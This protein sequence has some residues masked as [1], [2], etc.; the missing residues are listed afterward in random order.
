MGLC[1][2]IQGRVEQRDVEMYRSR[3]ALHVLS[4]NWGVGKKIE[5]I[6]KVDFKGGVSCL[7]VLDPKLLVGTLF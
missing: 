5:K 6:Q 7:E 3:R 1:G 4:F 2:G